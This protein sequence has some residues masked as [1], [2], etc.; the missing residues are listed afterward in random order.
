MEYK[1][2]T[3]GFIS[4]G[5]IITIVIGFASI[6][7]DTLNLNTIT[8]NIEVIKHPSPPSSIITTDP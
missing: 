5:I 1:T 8:T 7:I 3:G 2:L 4:L 6:I